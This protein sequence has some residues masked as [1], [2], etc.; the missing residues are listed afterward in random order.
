MIVRALEMGVSAERL[1]KALNVDIA[2]IRRL[3]TMLEGIC[4][5]VIEIVKDKRLNPRVFRVMR[6]MKPLRQIEV[7]ELMVAAGN[8]TVSYAEML[9]VGT[10][11]QDL[12]HPGRPRRLGGLSSEQIAK[13]EHELEIVSGDFR[14]AQEAYGRNVFDLVLAK[15]YIGRLLRNR[16]V[17]HFLAHNHPDIYEGF[18]SMISEAPIEAARSVA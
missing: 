5:D 9:L 7:A 13:M 14:N 3:R 12:L 11:Q 15:G 10:K 17:S 6:R 1:A 2:H 16:E 18:K 8:Y 4:A